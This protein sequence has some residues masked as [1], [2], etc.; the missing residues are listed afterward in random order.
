MAP[1]LKL[2]LS[3]WVASQKQIVSYSNLARKP[4]FSPFTPH[5]IIMDIYTEKLNKHALN[6]T[7]CPGSS[8]G[9]CCENETLYSACNKSTDHKYQR[10]AVHWSVPHVQNQ[11]HKTCE[12]TETAI[13][14][15]GTS[16]FCCLTHTCRDESTQQGQRQRPFVKTKT[17]VMRTHPVQI[18]SS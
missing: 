18:E 8:P 7:R 12:T 15:T 10:M 17:A 13:I 14:N 1:L 3:T 16:P 4:D 5:I 2:P 11:N 6:K 9:L